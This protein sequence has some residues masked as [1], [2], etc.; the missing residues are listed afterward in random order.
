[1]TKLLYTKDEIIDG[2]A[3]IAKLVADINLDIKKPSDCLEVKLTDSYLRVGT[4]SDKF[5]RQIRFKEPSCFNN[6]FSSVAIEL[7]NF[8]R[9][10]IDGN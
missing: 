6:T 4:A 9:T 2:V 7:T 10:N 8:K 1:M 3:N 5:F